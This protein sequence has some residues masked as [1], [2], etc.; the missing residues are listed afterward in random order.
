MD[1]VFLSRSYTLLFCSLGPVVNTFPEFSSPQSFQYRN[2]RADGSLL[3]SPPAYIPTYETSFVPTHQFPQQLYPP[4][5][6]P[7][8]LYSAGNH[9]SL[10]GAPTLQPVPSDYRG[11]NH[12]LKFTVKNGV[13]VSEQ[14]TYYRNHSSDPSL[15]PRHPLPNVET[16]GQTQDVKR[17]HELWK[18]STSG[19]ET[20]PHLLKPHEKQNSSSSCSRSQLQPLSNVIK[21]ENETTNTNV[22]TNCGQGVPTKTEVKR[23]ESGRS[24][25]GKINGSIAKTISQNK[26]EHCMS[27]SSLTEDR[28]L[29]CVEE[30]VD[31]KVDFPA[32]FRLV[33]LEAS[34][35]VHEESLIRVSF[36]SNCIT[37]LILFLPFAGFLGESSK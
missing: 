22:L 16:V 18:S 28:S 10:T 25:S 31:I 2:S 13:G 14:R 7:R 32:A 5:Y 12:L 35:K 33:Q 21:A 15:L 36:R 3:Y 29:F 20:N 23:P 6:A 27:L 11:A 17:E 1:S 19:K 26:T 8:Y 24:P 37:W 34:E 9:S 30:I 4:G